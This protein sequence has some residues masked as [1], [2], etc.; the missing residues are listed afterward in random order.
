MDDT[1]A[2]A[3]QEL[4]NA[5]AEIPFNQVLG[6]RLEDLN[7]DAISLRFAL[8]PELIGNYHQHILH[9]GVISS[10]LDMAGG[11]A[12]MTSVIA[13]NIDT[14]LAHIKNIL[15]KTSTIDLH[16]HYLKPGNSH[17]FIAKAKVQHSGN[18][19]CFT[20]MELYTEEQ[21]LIATGTAT[22]LIG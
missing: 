11:V 19:I 5:F 15:S 16:I 12:A 17:A 6:L 4:H 21:T 22:Y 18:K 14:N 7:Q 10:V 20:S 2:L 13:K 9:G 8:K 1:Q 3:L